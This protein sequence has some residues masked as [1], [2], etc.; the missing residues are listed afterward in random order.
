LFSPPV[1]YHNSQVTNSTGTRKKT[2]KINKLMLPLY[3]LCSSF[4]TYRPSSFKHFPTLSC[5]Q[6]SELP[7]AKNDAGCCP[8]HWRASDCTSV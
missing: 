7:D 6:A 4:S 1:I 5:Q 8:S 2:N 3:R